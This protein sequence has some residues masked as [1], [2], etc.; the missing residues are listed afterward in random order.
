MS[1]VKEKKYQKC[2]L[3]QEELSGSR[4]R[5]KWYNVPIEEHSMCPMKNNPKVVQSYAYRVEN[6]WGTSF[7]EE[8]TK[9]VT[10]QVCSEC[11]S[12]FRW[13][14]QKSELRL[15]SKE[16]HDWLEGEPW[17]HIKMKRGHK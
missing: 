5:I 15:V 4:E 14:A 16:A 6:L 17:K 1:K 11:L 12:R 8:K 13:L 9:K 10:F 7:Y 2:D 3:C